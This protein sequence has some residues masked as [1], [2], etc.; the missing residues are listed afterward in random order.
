MTR[1]AQPSV[2][3]GCPIISSP[4]EVR[5]RT[6]LRSRSGCLFFLIF[7]FRDVPQA[8]EIGALA[9]R[10]TVVFIDS[11]DDD[12]LGGEPVDLG[13]TLGILAVAAVGC[14]SL[15]YFLGFAGA[16]PIMS[17]SFS[18]E[19]NVRL[20]DVVGRADRFG[21]GDAAP[22]P[23]GVKGTGGGVGGAS[24][25]SRARRSRSR[26]ASRLARVSSS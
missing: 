21:A 6:T 18:S 3:N 11:E 22:V 23:V 20:E 19:V 5:A 25:A 26:A 4:R 9:G 12:D 24:S 16:P 1:Q 8:A 14:A 2:H 13:R 15:G 10:K 17:W 7:L